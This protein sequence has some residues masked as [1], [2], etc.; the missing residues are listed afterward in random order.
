[1][2]KGD[3][4]ARYG[5]DEFA[6]LL[7]MAGGTRLTDLADTLL[8][9][10]RSQVFLQGEGR[11][12][13]ITVSIGMAEFPRDA[14]DPPG[15]FTAAQKALDKAKEN[16]GDRAVPAALPLVDWSRN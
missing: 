16:G 10:I 4:A 9:R 14:G 5:G 12:A 11:S 7:P 1:V 3:A 8:K 6:M 2:R 15:L 13:R